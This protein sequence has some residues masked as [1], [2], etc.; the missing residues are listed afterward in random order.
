VGPASC[1]RA[2]LLAGFLVKLKLL[3]FTARGST[4]P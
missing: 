3:E 2:D 4:N 1:R